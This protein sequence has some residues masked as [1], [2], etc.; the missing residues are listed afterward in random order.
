MFHNLVEHRSE[1]TISFQSHPPCWIISIYLS[2]LWR[3]H[4]IIFDWTTAKTDNCHFSSIVCNRLIRR[5]KHVITPASLYA[6]ENITYSD[7][8]WNSCSL[9]YLYILTSE[10][11]RA[12]PTHFIG[13]LANLDSPF[14][15]V[16][17]LQWVS[18]C[19]NS[20]GAKIEWLMM[21]L[22]SWAHQHV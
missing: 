19:L 17:M 12:P 14:C 18:S 2:W 11:M 4:E 21:W 1:N 9:H 16:V 3:C 13:C 7:K 8:Y 10:R 15:L 6:I 20:N 5:Y 22:F